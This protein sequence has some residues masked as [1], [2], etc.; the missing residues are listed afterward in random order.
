M[1]MDKDFSGEYN[2]IQILVATKLMPPAC[3]DMIFPNFPGAVVREVYKWSDSDKG[4]DV[5]IRGL[6]STGG[7]E[8]NGLVGIFEGT[9]TSTGRVTV[10]FFDDQLRRWR[11]N[12]KPQNVVKNGP[13]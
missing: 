5:E 8:L 3:V 1:S 9:Q 4:C 10:S 7:Q 2:G 13:R 12:F 11:G 6:T